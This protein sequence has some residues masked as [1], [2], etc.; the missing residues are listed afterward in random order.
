MEFSERLNSYLEALDVS[1]KDLSEE[2]G[3]S[4]VVI[5]R[6]RSGQR[7]PSPE[8]TGVLI[9]LA[10]GIESLSKKLDTNVIK[11]SDVLEAFTEDLSDRDNPFCADNFNLLVETFSLNASEMSHSMSYDPSYISRIRSGK[12][13]P[14]RPEEF[15]TKLSDFILPRLGKSIPTDKFLNLL[16][17]EESEEI[18]QESLKEM[19]RAFLI[20]KVRPDSKAV[21]SFLKHVDEFNLNDFIKE[22]HYDDIKIPSVPF[23]FPKEKTYYGIEGQKEAEI[24]IFKLIVLSKSKDPVVLYSDMEMEELAKDQE[25]QKKWLFGL[26]LMLKKGLLLKYIH[27]LDRPMNEMMLGLENL[28]PLYMTGQIEPYYLPDRQNDVFRHIYRISGTA[29]MTGSGISGNSEGN[30]YQVSTSKNVVAGIRLQTDEILAHALPLMEIYNEDRT[31]EFMKYLKA[32]R[33]DHSDICQILSGLPLHTLSD[34]MLDKMLSRCDASE[35]QKKEAKTICSIAKENIKN[36]LKENTACVE[37]PALTEEEFRENPLALQIP[38]SSL[39][40]KIVYT[41]EE[42]SRHLNATEEFASANAGYT[43]I[44][45][46]DTPF[47]NINITISKGNHVWIS[48]MLSPTIQFIIRHPELREAIEQGY[49]PSQK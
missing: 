30:V 16:G 49:I 19:L 26:A 32:L 14:P 41:Y 42:Y 27:N 31:E 9:E 43:L 8:N 4:Q 35:K 48:K 2:C 47:K 46:I 6:Y 29:A 28:I 22:I 24:D 45:R 1:G 5:C 36:T 40:G 15:I 20:K 23:T 3:V 11:A 13:R 34:D 44:K 12:R 17:I 21:E 25:F 10:M 18:T 7:V 33:N 37:I 38:G 39:T